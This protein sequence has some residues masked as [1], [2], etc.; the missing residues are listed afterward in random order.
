[1]FMGSLSEVI[2]TSIANIQAARGLEMTFAGLTITFSALGT[3]SIVVGLMP[4]ILKVVNKI[5]PEK[6]GHHNA[7]AKPQNNVT[8]EVIAAIGLA[9]HSLKSSGK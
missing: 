6:S 1:M 9:F 5:M 3:I 7:A 2:Q 4:A 8:G